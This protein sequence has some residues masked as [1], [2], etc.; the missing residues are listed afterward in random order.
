MTVRSFSAS[1][2]TEN[3]TPTIL[4]PIITNHWWLSNDC[5]IS[6]SIKLCPNDT[7]G[8]D[9][10]CHWSDVHVA[11][12]IVLLLLKKFQFFRSWPRLSQRIA[13]KWYEIY[14]VGCTGWRWHL[15]PLCEVQ[16]HDTMKQSTTRVTLN[17][18][19]RSAHSVSVIFDIIK[20][21]ES[22]QFCNNAPCVLSGLYFAFQSIYHLTWSLTL[23]EERRL[24]MFENRM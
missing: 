12:S 17:L 18:V 8:G 11:F 15:S 5:N 23:R 24:R 4:A 6:A 10:L 22:P 2:Q 9:D 21:G 14:F 7:V 13:Y 1:H 19:W 16:G 20:V 3:H